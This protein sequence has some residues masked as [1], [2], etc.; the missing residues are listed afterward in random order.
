VDNACEQEK[1]E[2]RKMLNAKRAKES[3]TS[4]HC[5]LGVFYF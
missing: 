1:L 2:A 5:L 3:L 4:G